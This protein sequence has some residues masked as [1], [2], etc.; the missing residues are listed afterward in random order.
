M[1]W[2]EQGF[3]L[4][5]GTVVDATLMAASTST[6]HR[7]RQ[8]DPEMHSTCKGRQGHFG[9]NLH[10]GLDRETGLVPHL[11]TTAAHV[12]DSQVTPQ[13]LHGAETDVW[14]DTAYLRQD[15]KLR[16]V[17]SQATLRF[18]LKRPRGG[19]RTRLQQAAHRQLVHSF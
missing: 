19:A 17:A 11:V 10:I 12:H 1:H 14:G 2:E 13:R 4:R 5:Q 3:H 16:A 9:M 6:Q 7:Q 15:V 8:R 18:Q